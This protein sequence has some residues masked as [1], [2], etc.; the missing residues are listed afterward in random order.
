MVST[1]ND[2]D[3]PEDDIETNWCIMMINVS[4]G[5]GDAKQLSAQR[6]WEEGEIGC[7]FAK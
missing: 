4:P 1:D 7:R 3:H 2:I 6:P 5:R